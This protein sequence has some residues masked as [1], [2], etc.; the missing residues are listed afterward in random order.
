[1]IVTSPLRER[2]PIVKS[3]ND[4]V[5]IYLFGLSDVEVLGVAIRV[6]WYHSFAH[7]AYEMR[8]VWL[9]CHLWVA[10]ESLV[11]DT[12]VG[13]GSSSSKDGTTRLSARAH[14]R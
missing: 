4:G 10:S 7:E 11:N 9:A 8:K 5:I 13:K 12:S 6:F 1:M 14:V 2:T 3:L